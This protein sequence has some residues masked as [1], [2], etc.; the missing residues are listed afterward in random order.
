MAFPIDPSGSDLQAFL[1][2]NYAKKLR[3][4]SRALR[5]YLNQGHV[6][7]NLAAL[8]WSGA[9]DPA[10]LCQACAP[11]MGLICAQAPAEGWLSRCYDY[12][13]DGLF[14]DRDFIR[15][16]LGERKA[17]E[18]FLSILEYCIKGEAGRLPHSL[19]RDPSPVPQAELATTRVQEDFRR[20]MEHTAQS[21]YLL[22]LRIAPCALP[23]DP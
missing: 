6:L 4:S 17:L 1:Q 13:A 9:T 8:D 23:Y 10:A 5:D 7:E 12:L 11:A 16:R 18:L 14:P 19:L 21:R 2:E 15:P 20:F 3:V 22:L